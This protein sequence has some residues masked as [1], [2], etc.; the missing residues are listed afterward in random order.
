MSA[1]Y[2]G[3]YIEDTYEILGI[4]ENIGNDTSSEIHLIATIFD[5]NNTLVGIEETLPIFDVSKKGGHSPFKFII[6]SNKTLFDHYVIEIG[7][8]EKVNKN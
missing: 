3:K 1:L 7:G 6:Y 8:S 4:I 5:K 2:K